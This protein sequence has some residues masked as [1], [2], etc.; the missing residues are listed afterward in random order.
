MLA[1][2]GRTKIATLYE[3]EIRTL[4][5]H[6]VLPLVRFIQSPLAENDPVRRHAAMGIAADLA[7]IWLIPDLIDLLGHSDGY[8]RRQA[9]ATLHRLTALDM[10]LSPERWQEKPNEEQTMAREDWKT[11]WAKH[12]DQ[13][14]SP[15]LQITKE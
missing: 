1:Q 7:P 15:R 2:I 14:P 11:W 12:R 6:G 4:G 9:A 3:Q 8:I 13:Y 5:E 10:N